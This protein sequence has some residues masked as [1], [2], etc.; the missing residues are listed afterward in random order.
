MNNKPAQ[1]KVILI[2]GCSS[3]FGLLIAAR[4]ASKG[5]I[6]YASMRSLNKKDALLNEVNK[7]EGAV[8]ILQLDVTDKISI[9]KYGKAES[10]NAGVATAVI[11]SEFKRR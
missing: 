7:R 6:V 4:L 10:L 5:H 3:G 9:P 8:R 2:T 11:C 1:Q